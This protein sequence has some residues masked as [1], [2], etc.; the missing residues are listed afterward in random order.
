MMLGR[1]YGRKGEN[2]YCRPKGICGC[3]LP[4]KVQLIKC[5]LPGG[6]R[7]PKPKSSSSCWTK[8]NA[9]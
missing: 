7:C 3:D 4:L 5:V 9:W 8:A 1:A 2:T 6:T